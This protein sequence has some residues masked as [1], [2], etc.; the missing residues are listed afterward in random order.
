MKDDRL[1]P[2]AS[3]GDTSIAIVALARPASK[4]YLMHPNHTQDRHIYIKR[5]PVPP[6]SKK[7]K[8]KRKNAHPGETH[9][10][11]TPVTPP[12]KKKLEFQTSK[13]SNIRSTSGI[14][15]H[16]V[17]SFSSPQQSGNDELACLPARQPTT[18]Q[19]EDPNCLRCK[20]ASVFR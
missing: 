19:Q 2:P 11:T 16:K 1:V 9:H 7:Q 18:T 5:V 6:V 13:N 15:A 14:L 20:H 12:P 17:P 4:V 8:N 3:S 10:T